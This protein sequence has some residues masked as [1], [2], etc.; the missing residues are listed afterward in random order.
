MTLIAPIGQEFR[1]SRGKT[2][3]N[4]FEFLN[5]LNSIT[6]EEF[7]H[8]VNK[9]RND[10]FNWVMF[11]LREHRLAYR[12]MHSRSLDECRAYVSSFLKQATR[13]V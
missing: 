5:I 4:V 3:H 7:E 9:Q 6:R 10:F 12:L 11:S 8:H 2:A 13:K 1:F